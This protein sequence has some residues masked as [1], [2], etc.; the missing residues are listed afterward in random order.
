MGTAGPFFGTIFYLLVLF[1]AL[2]S[3]IGLLEGVVSALM[4]RAIDKG[5]KANRTKLCW[6]II[7]TVSYTHLDVYKRQAE[8]KPEA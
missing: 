4:D 8:E 5:K 2:T 6:G 3:S 1:A 7:A